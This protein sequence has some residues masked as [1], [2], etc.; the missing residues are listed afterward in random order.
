MF[1]RPGRTCV[2]I[3]GLWGQLKR[4]VAVAEMQQCWKMH[5]ISYM[6]ASM[7]SYPVYTLGCSLLSFRK[8]VSFFCSELPNSMPPSVF[9]LLII[10]AGHINLRPIDHG[11]TP[12]SNTSAQPTKK[13][14][15]RC[16]QRSQS[17]LARAKDNTLRS[18]TDGN[19][20]T[21][22]QFAPEILLS[23]ETRLQHQSPQARWMT[24]DDFCC[25][26]GRFFIKIW[27]QAE[28]K[29]RSVW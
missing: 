15:L 3:G 18:A 10:S 16:P 20:L 7:Q 11:N 28:D 17:R 6:H 14:H 5:S 27:H 25:A 8:T 24:R 4:P 23:N 29:Y 22:P 19:K 2:C 26:K 9:S 13:P 21:S 1:S 12:H